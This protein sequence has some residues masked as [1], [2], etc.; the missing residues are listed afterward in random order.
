MAVIAAA[1]TTGGW[2]MGSF[3]LLIFFG[4]AP[5]FI[6]AD[7]ADSSSSILEKMELVLIA[8]GAALI[9]HAVV[10]D[11]SVVVAIILAI[12]YTLAFVAHAWARQ[13]LGIRT[14]KITLIL[15]WLAI[16]YVILKLAA[17]RSPFLADSLALKE[18]WTR[19]TIH[20]GYLGS[21]FWILIVNFSFYMAFLF[22]GSLKWGWLIAGI[23]LLGGPIVYSYTLSGPPITRE[24]MINLYGNVSSVTDVTYLA[25]GE[26]VV[27]TA[28]W[29][30]VLMLLFTLV[31]HQTRKK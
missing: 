27:R 30:S 21:S 2:L 1:L 15:F 20:T 22:G 3:P 14:G 24:M 28:A 19:W 31:K 26:W 7:A 16:E 9:A 18:D 4:L 17:G 12:A 25:R 23:L 8:L 5:L 11:T 10:Y 13:T 6:L 29:I